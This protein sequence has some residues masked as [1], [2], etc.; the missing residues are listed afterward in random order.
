MSLRAGGAGGRAAAGEDGPFAHH[1]L[2]FITPGSLPWEA[3][4]RKQIRQRPNLR[5]NALGRPQTGQRL[6][7]RTLN[8][9]VRIAFSLSDVFAKSSS[10]RSRLWAPPAA[11]PYRTA[12]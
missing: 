2:D 4:L 3:M 5:R 9:G 11:H 8:F 12:F 1:Q 10:L 7:A 6:Y